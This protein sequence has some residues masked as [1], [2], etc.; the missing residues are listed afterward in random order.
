MMKQNV[1]ANVRQLIRKNQSGTSSS[2]TQIQYLGDINQLTQQQLLPLKAI[3][4]KQKEGSSVL[5]QLKPYV[6][7]NYFDRLMM[8]PYTTLTQQQKTALVDMIPMIATTQINKET[9]RS[10][11]NGISDQRLKTTLLQK[12]NELSL[13]GSAGA[14]P[15]VNE[16]QE[17]QSDSSIPLLGGRK[18]KM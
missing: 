11:I 9:L 16:L 4:Q 7:M 8:K 15:I 13:H 2:K 3:V 12:F 6:F 1:R 10:K 5:S 18:K 14:P 17:D